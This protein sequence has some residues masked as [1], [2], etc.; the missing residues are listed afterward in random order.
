MIPEKIQ[1][2]SAN[3]CAFPSNADASLQTFGTNKLLVPESQKFE[4]PVPLVA[5]WLLLFDH[6]SGY[7]TVKIMSFKA[8]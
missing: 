2:I 7:F 8:N 5:W 1:Q 3:I 6:E 4:G